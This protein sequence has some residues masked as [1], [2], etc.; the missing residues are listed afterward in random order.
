MSV[1]TVGEPT[2]LSNRYNS[3]CV[4]IK[5]TDLIFNSSTNSTQESFIV[6]IDNT[7][8]ATNYNTTSLL[9]CDVINDGVPFYLEIT[10]SR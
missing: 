4:E 2:V 1:S 7:T 6:S 8:V 9:V 10:S 3:T 5:W